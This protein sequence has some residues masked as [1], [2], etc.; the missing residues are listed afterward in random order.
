MDNDYRL[1]MCVRFLLPLNGGGFTGDD[2]IEAAMA[3]PVNP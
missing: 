1:K 3:L 2:K